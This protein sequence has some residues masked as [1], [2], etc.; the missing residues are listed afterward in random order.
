MSAATIPTTMRAAVLHTVG[1]PL[2]VQEVA[3]SQ[4]GAHEVLV[5][6][7]ASGICHSDLHVCEHDTGHYPAPL[8]PGHEIAGVIVALGDAVAGLAVGDHIVACE[9]AHC[10]HCIDCISGRPFMCPNVHETERAEGATPRV[11]IGNTEVTAFAHIGGFAEYALMH[12]NSVVVIPDEMP[13][14]RAAILGCGVITGAGAAIN[15][16]SI[17]VGDTVAV[18]GCGGVGLSVIQGAILAGARRVIAIDVHD[19]KLELARKMGATDVINSAEVD[20]VGR[21]RELT[22]GLGVLYSFEVAGLKR[23][24]L[25]ALEMIRP[26]GTAFLIGIQAPDTVL[27]INPLVDLLFSKRN[28]RTVYMGNSNFKH[29]IPLL[30]EMYLQGRLNLD[31]MVSDRIALDD[32]QKGLEN[33]RSGSAARTVITTF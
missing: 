3:I 4:P 31:D 13:F 2:V 6:V 9:V 16:A 18:I 33:L 1:E 32:V 20:P 5:Q 10:G 22:G 11:S 30:A 29:D 17:R 8:V 28:L 19:N 27:E 23:T 24:A 14:D 21:V 15:A 7:K 12:E 26:S 25:Q